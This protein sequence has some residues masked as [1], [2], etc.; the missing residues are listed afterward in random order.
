MRSILVVCVGNICRS[1]MAEALLRAQ[2][3]DL[4]IASAGIGA[5][6][7]RAAD[8]MAQDLMQERGLDISAHRAQQVTK[9]LCQR[10]DLILVMDQ[11]QRVFIERNYP[12]MRGRVFQLVRNSAIPDPYRGTMSQFKDSL[13]LIERGISMWVERI[14]RV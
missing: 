13:A 4:A 3:P 7:G 12:F 5:L 1:P 2:L 9:L 8:V 11:E 14:K 6:I 10:A